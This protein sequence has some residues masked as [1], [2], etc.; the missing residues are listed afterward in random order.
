MPELLMFCS[1]LLIMV[2]EMVGAR[3][4]VPHVGTS[5]VV[6]TSLIGVVL[7]C[8]ALG[9]YAGGR[10]ADRRL[11]RRM[12]GHVLTL[13]G[14]SCA[15]MASCHQLI[16]SCTMAIDNLYLAALPGLCCGMLGPDIIRLRLARLETAGATVGRLYALSTAGRITGTFLGGFVLISW[17][18]S[19][20]IFWGVTLSMLL[21]ASPL[22]PWGGNAAARGAFSALSAAHGGRCGA[23][24]Q[25]AVA[26]AGKRLQQHPPV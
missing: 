14:V 11:S 10:L 26:A 2:L 18:P 16:D 4:L 20:V 23:G 5:T 25:G 6:W 17:L 9:S 7:A 12:L 13:A 1:G 3:V 24:S 8:L 15:V 19:G 22:R 21:L